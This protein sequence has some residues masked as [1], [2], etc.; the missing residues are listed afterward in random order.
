M[1]AVRGATV[2]GI[3]LTAFLAVAVVV[4]AVASAAIEFSVFL[5]IPA[6]LAG[7]AAAMVV[8]MRVLRHS[9]S[10]GTVAVG[11]AIAADGYAVL[12]GF[13]L[14]YAVSATR[15]VLSTAVIGGL[16]LAVGVAVGVVVWRSRS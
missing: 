16:S 11:A 1:D 12:A 14:R 8:A 4:T 15:D 9:P 10:R 2:V 5:G 3:G 13:A 7:A 6:G